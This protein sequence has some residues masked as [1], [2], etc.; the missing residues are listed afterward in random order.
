MKKQEHSSANLT[1][2]KNTLRGNTLT[3]YQILKK[4]L[5][6]LR[7][8]LQNNH[9]HKKS[10]AIVFYLVSLITLWTDKDV[11]KFMFSTWNMI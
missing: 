7:A 3:S 8:S 1:I 2:Q 11:C 9:H 4:P 6:R 5:A 10:D